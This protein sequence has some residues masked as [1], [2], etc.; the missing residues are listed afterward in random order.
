MS[1]AEPVPLIEPKDALNF[2]R[3]KGLQIGF[4]WLDVQRE[5]HDKAFTVAKAMTR[6]LLEDIRSAMDAAIAEGQTL[7]MFVKNLR[8]TL[9]VQGWWGR[10]AMADP[11]T[12]EVVDAQLGSPNRLRVIYRTNM[13][14]SYAAGRWARIQRNKKAFPL[15]RYVSVMDGR[16][17]DEH[18]A[19]HN[20]VL[21]VDHPWWETHYP[22][23]DWGCRCRAVPLNARMLSKKRLSVTE[24]PPHFGTREW[25]N[26]RTGEVRTIEKGI[27]AGWDYNPG[28]SVLSGIAPEPLPPGFGDQGAAAIPQAAFH[29]A[30]GLTEANGFQSVW[31]DAAGWP[32]AVTARMKDGEGQT[33]IAMLIRTIAAPDE[34]RWAWV[35]DESGMAVLM[36]RYV[37]GATIVDVGRLGWRV[38][39]AR[40]G[41]KTVWQ[42][43]RS[44]A[45]GFN[46]NQ[47]RHGKGNA[48]G[49]EFRATATAAV[50]RM[51]DH[52]G[53]TEYSFGPI[54]ATEAAQLKAATGFDA[55]GY[56]RIVATSEARHV[57]ASH[58]ANGKHL[59]KSTNEQIPVR[60][61]DFEHIPQIARDGQT[62]M[63]GKI[64]GN[65]P[66][67]IEHQMD[68]DGRRFVYLETV[69]TDTKTLRLKTLRIEKLR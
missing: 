40:P 4:S 58:G 15:L 36:R 18:R 56:E 43:R 14:T 52:G 33:R 44:V 34:I 61:A 66:A 35:T 23:C 28:A 30:F 10:K 37:R 59:R 49:G 13:R 45:A 5:E 3:A 53:S 6:E 7:A 65:K 51:W 9:E 32:M 29:K 62:K 63:I 27:G 20:T 60:P 67:R 68:M 1:E 41:G 19:W 47:P 50:G 54:D 39:K 64:G 22:P 25:T 46:P 17:R 26:K 55:T 57:R 2:F 38:G 11:Q 8:P 24:K 16:E 12:G 48:R 42:R 69:G 21:P 31:I